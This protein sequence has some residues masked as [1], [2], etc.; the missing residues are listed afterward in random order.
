MEMGLVRL[1]LDI[2]LCVYELFRRKVTLTYSIAPLHLH[3]FRSRCNCNVIN[4]IQP[5]PVLVLLF[6]QVKLM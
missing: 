3:P 4:L 2:P 1:K 5:F 6:G